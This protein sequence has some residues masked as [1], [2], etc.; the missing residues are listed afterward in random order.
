VERFERAVMKF[1]P[2]EW[3]L[4]QGRFNAF[5]SLAFN[6]GEEI[7]TP[8]APLRDVGLALRAKPDQRG[9]DKMVKAVLE[10]TVSDGVH[11]PGLKLR[12]ADEAKL[13]KRNKG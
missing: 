11:Q 1:V 2:Q 5:V 10:F 8:Q 3:R 13:I 9:V 4:S 6:L 12:R 7:L